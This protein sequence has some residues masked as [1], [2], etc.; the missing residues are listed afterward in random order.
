[1]PIYSGGLGILAG[2]HVKAS[3]DLGIPL[4]GDRAL[5]R[6][7]LLPQRLDL[8]GRQHED[9]IDVDSRLLPIEPATPATARRSRSRST[10]AR[11]ASPRASGGS[12]SAAT[13]C[14]CSTPTSRQQP[15]RSRPDRAALR[16]R[17]ARPHP[18][19]A[20]ARRWRRARADRARHFTRRHSSQRRTQRVR[21]ARAGAAADGSPKASPRTK[22]SAAS[23]RRSSSPRTRRCRRDTIAFRPISSRNISGRCAKRSASTDALPGARARESD[24]DDE[25]FCMTVLALKLS[26]RANAV[27]S[28]HGQVS[29]AMWTPLYP[30]VARRA[31]ADRPHHQRRARAH[32]ARAADAPGLRPSPWRRLA[33]RAAESTGCWE[34][35]R[36]ASTTASCGRRIRR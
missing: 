34:A 31:G 25:D 1:M 13:R 8:D 18:A 22:P 19:G 35:M 15:G 12:P 30:G 26:R 2:D 27:S 10:R 6:S 28:L 20:A 29:R 4:V 23:P 17:R 32:L 33:G 3:S 16:R 14:F 36:R 7:G 9:Y 5:L 11:A 24:D 21:R